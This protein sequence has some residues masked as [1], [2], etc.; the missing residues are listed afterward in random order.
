MAI[1]DEILRRK[2]ERLGEAK[3][4][5]PLREIKA[6]AAEADPPLDFSKAVKRTDRIKLIAEVKKASP[7]KGLI[8]PD[9]DPQKIASIYAEKAHAVSVLTEEDFFEGS[10]SYINIVKKNSGLPVLRKDFI[11]DEY[12]VYESRAAGADSILLIAR[13]LEMAQA[14]EY[15]S[16][17]RELGMAVLFEVHDMKELET[18]LK[19]NAPVI[20]INNRD[21]NTLKIDL[22]RTF[23]LKT[24]MPA[25]KI[26][27][28]ESG[29]DTREHVL[30]LSEAGVDA[31]LVGT[32][33][34]K[35]RDIAKKIDELMGSGNDES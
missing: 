28:S 13:I 25:N 19:L 26:V 34:M 11:I 6:R 18:A 8:R 20:G 32:A 31:V 24:E 17:A 23:E 30:R 22:A 16:M 2:K 9:W 15:M 4:K 14:E 33:I 35:E 5:V 10:L 1:L 12:Q 29:I 3:R 21:L 27:I 7:S